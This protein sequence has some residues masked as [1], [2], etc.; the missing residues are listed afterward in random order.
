MNK[1]KIIVYK[2]LHKILLFHIVIICMIK[3]QKIIKINNVIVFR[4]N[5]IAIKKQQNFFIKNIENTLGFLIKIF[6]KHN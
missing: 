5:K 4:H 6:P 2:Q 3:N 1:T